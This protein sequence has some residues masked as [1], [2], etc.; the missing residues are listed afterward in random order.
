VIS[1]VS[2]LV[3]IVARPAITLASASYSAVTLRAGRA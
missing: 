2:F 3:L 1:P